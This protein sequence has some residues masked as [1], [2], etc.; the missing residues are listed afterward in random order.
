MGMLDKDSSLEDIR[1]W[2]DQATAAGFQ[3]KLNSAP[4]EFRYQILAALMADEKQG[5]EVK[6]LDERVPL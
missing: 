3:E 4:E 5:L 1:H 6:A 2:I